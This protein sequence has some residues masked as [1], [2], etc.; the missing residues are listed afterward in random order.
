MGCCTV[1][2]HIGLFCVHIRETTSKPPP[3]C[4]PWEATRRASRRPCP[5]VALPVH[6]PRE[7]LARPCSASRAERHLVGAVER[8]CG[9]HHAPLRGT[10][11]LPGGAATGAAKLAYRGAD[12]GLVGGEHDAL[13]EA[14]FVVGLLR[15]PLAGH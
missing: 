7:R 4:L 8:D 1:A 5:T 14:P 2:A 3:Y 13:G 12:A 10:E 9:A 15:G 6:N 11:Q